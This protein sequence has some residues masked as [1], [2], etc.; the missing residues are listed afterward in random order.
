[1]QEPKWAQCTE[2][3]LWKFVAYHLAKVDIASVLVGGAVVS[4]YSKG[5]YRSGDVDLVTY[6]H[7]HKE[8]DRIMNQIGFKK[9][10][11]H[12]RHP[13]CK[14]L[15]VQSV[16]GPLGIG[17]D[18]KII[19]RTITVEGKEIRILTPTDCIRDRLS[20]YI[21]DRARA[22]L[23]QAALVAN[24]QA[25]SS[26]KIKTWLKKEGFESAYNELLDEMKQLKNSSGS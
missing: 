8:L 23:T 15:Y 12:Y 4:V 11:M 14:H 5:L 7:S 13:E 17:D 21:H 19:P 22:C 2:E 16:S 6:E 20:A 26:T 1:M 10:G 18:H 25:F 3:E 24:T 9:N